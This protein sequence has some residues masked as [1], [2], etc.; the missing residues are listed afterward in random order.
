[1]LKPVHAVVLLLLAAP[2]AFAQPRMDIRT[3]DLS[4][5]AKDGVLRFYL[6]V[7]DVATRRAIEGLDAGKFTLFLD[8]KAVPKEQITKVSLTTRAQTAEPIAVAVLLSDYRGFRSYSPGEPD[9][10]QL[11]TRGTAKLFGALTPQ[12]DTVAVWKYD[13]SSLV[14]PIPVTQAVASAAKT[15]TELVR[16]PTKLEGG[17]V[18][19][20]DFYRHL[21]TVVETLSAMRDKLPRRVVLVVVSDGV[22]RHTIEQRRQIENRLSRC[23]DRARQY[24]IEIHA[25]GAF[26]QDDQFLPFVSRAA[27]ETRGRYH[28]VDD[29]EKLEEMLAALPSQLNTELVLEVQTRALSTTEKVVVRLD[30]E[31]PTGTTASAKYPHRLKLKGRR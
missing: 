10:F 31:T 9:V 5:L 2:L 16:P 21:E 3:V 19:T 14:Y 22:G 29:P 30:V 17:E 11:M 27:V 12:R 4:S 8:D 23:I 24:R 25:Y 20:P 7:Y 13:E 1:M 18:T 28:A 15:A 6:D 26:M